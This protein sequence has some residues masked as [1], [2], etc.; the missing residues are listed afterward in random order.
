MALTFLTNL[1]YTVF[2]T[3]SFFTTLLKLLKSNRVV[4]NFPI[5]SSSTLVFKLLKLLVTFLNLSISHL[6]TSDFKL[7][8]SVFF[9]RSDVLT[10]VAFFKSAFIA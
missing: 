6:S 8:K 10:L 4:S 9:A 2:L 7:A 5:S 3:T 1:S